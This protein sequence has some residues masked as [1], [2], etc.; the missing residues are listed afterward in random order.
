MIRSSARRSAYWVIGDVD[1]HRHRQAV[2]AALGQQR[3]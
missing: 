3:A 2:S 1:P